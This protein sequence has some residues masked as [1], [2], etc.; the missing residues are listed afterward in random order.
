MGFYRLVTTPHLIDP[1]E[2]AYHSH[3][4]TTLAEV[5][6][7]AE[8]MQIEVML[9]YEALLTPDLP[10]RLAG[11]EPVTLAGSRAV[12][13]ELPFAAWP[14]HA[15][16]TLFAL[17]TAGF[18]PILAHPE[19]YRTLI[20]DPNRGIQ[21]ADRGVILQLTIGSLA[22]LFGKRVQHTAET[23]LRAG[24]IDLVATDAH[25]AGHRLS[26]VPKGLTRL[27]RLVGA[28]EVRRLTADVPAALLRDAPLLP[29]VAESD[30]SPARWPR[31]L[32][33][34]FSR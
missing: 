23:W 32:T 6:A 28:A 14:R 18:R 4:S 26:A 3:I 2:D 15:E 30:T 1:L 16:T 20:D 9:G 17:Q 7:V 19:R 22:G 8:P 27:E 25:S 11:G 29:R 33:R 34:M 10:A 31:S 24:A 13:V 21:L 12:L 5:R